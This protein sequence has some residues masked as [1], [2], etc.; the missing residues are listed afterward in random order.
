MDYCKWKKINVMRIYRT[1]IILSFFFTGSSVYGQGNLPGEEVDVIKKFDARIGNASMVK[2]VPQVLRLD[3][4]QQKSYK[5]EVT[6]SPLKIT[7]T[8]EKLRPI[9]MPRKKLGDAYN[10]YVR[11]AYGLPNSIIG[12]ANYAFSTESGFEFG[13]HLLHNSVNNSKNLENQRYMYNNAGVKI[14]QVFDG[15]LRLGAAIDYSMDDNY[16][17]AYDHEHI[18]YTKEE[19]LR[20]KHDFKIETSLSNSTPTESGINYGLRFQYSRFSNNVATRQNDFNLYLSGTKWFADKNPLTLEIGTE[21]T[22]LRD[23]IKRTLNNFFLKPSFTLHNSTYKLKLG[24]S[25]YSNNDLFYFFPDVEFDIY[26]GDSR[27]IAFVG[28]DGGL[29]KNTYRTL[30][31]YNPYVEARLDTI[32]NTHDRR[33]YG[34]LKGQV[35]HISYRATVGYQTIKAL[36]TYNPILSSDKGYY[37]VLY[38]D[39]SRIL[40]QG[41]LSYDISES[42][43]LMFTASKSFYSLKPSSHYGLPSFELNTRLEYLLLNDKLR[44]WADFYLQ[45]P[46]HFHIIPDMA[47]QSNYRY[48]MNLGGEYFFSKHFGVNL[49]LFNIFNNKYYRWFN[50]PSIEFQGLI[51]LTARF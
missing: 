36:A 37:N 24:L 12:R 17:Y 19:A 51:G 27:F 31:R 16:Y 30:A 32:A 50:A 14:A 49:Q 6:S 7:Y 8:P 3:T 28:A 40:L 47:I 11:A 10:G 44:L 15:G 5:Y 46:I 33:Y 18:S 1:L 4:F 29:S 41:S 22:T 48:D 34:G 23:T 13:L 42:L 21:F 25:L 39:G 38:A 45:D 9:A 20:R 43:N 35:K 2:N 26:L